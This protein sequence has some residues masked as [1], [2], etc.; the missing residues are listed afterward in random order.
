MTKPPTGA[1]SPK[2]GWLLQSYFYEYLIAQRQVSPRTVTAYRDVFRLLLRFAVRRDRRALA[3][4]GL[5]DLN[6]ELVLAFL[7]HLERERGNTA[8]TRN[9]RCAPTARFTSG[10]RF[11]P[12]SSR[13]DLVADERC[14]GATGG[15]EAS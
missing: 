8:R 12:G 15:T 6:R 3:E 1:D 4:M 7:E 13:F 11:H 9:V 14:R 2:L 5:Q 10:G